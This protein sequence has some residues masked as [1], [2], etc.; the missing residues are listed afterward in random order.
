MIACKDCKF[1]KPSGGLL[2]WINGSRWIS[3]RCSHKR[4]TQRVE[5]EYHLGEADG[6]VTE[7][8]S[9]RHM[10]NP[11]HFDP[12]RHCGHEAQYFDPRG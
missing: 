1:S 5:P 2:A 10:R 8:E 12:V 3:A 7:M 11:R 6:K 4:A 9:C